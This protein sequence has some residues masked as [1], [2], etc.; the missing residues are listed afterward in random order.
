MKYLL[1]ITMTLPTFT[2]AAWE[3]ASTGDT[4]YAMSPNVQSFEPMHSPYE[5]VISHVG[6]GCKTNGLVW[7]YF[8]FSQT[9]NMLD[10]YNTEDTYQSVAHRIIYWDNKVDTI[11][12]TQEWNS[13][14]LH[15]TDDVYVIY[16]LKKH[17]Y[18]TLD[19]SA[20]YGADKDIEF[21]YDLQGSTKAIDTIF[22]KCGI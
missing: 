19:M 11:S 22:S 13:P 7:A 3:I 21:Q 1:F 9:P 5:E 18:A 12:L 8:G 17:Y 4:H 15:V 6:V 20:W 14:F 16:H 2:H 10:D